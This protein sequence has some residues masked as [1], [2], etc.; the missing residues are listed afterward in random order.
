MIDA[1]KAIVGSKGIVQGEDVTAR[2]GW[3]G[4]ECASQ[5]LVRPKSTEE[6]SQVVALCYQNNQSM[7]VHGGRTGLVGGANADK[8][9]IIISLERMNQIETVNVENRTMV[10]EAGAILA[11]VQ[12]QAQQKNLEFTLDLG[13]R[14]SATVGGV[15]STNAGGNQVIRYGAARDQVL[16][17]EVV[18]PDGKVLNCM[19]QMLK[20]NAGYDLKHLF[21]GAEGSLGIITKA[22]IQLRPPMPHK[23]SALVAVN[24]FKHL[25]TLLNVCGAE[26]N[27]A[28]TAFEVM[29][30]SFI[31]VAAF[32]TRLP[33]F[34][35]S[36]NY[37]FYVLI[38][39]SG[40]NDESN[41]QQFIKTLESCIENELIVD[42]LVAQSEKERQYLW[43][44]RDNIDY[45]MSQLRPFCNF[46]IS[47]PIDTME[48]YI[49]TIKQQ[50]EQ[51][52]GD[53][54]WVIFG[55]LGDSNLHIIVS[56]DESVENCEQA[57]ETIVYNNLV[58]CN[59]SITA[60]HGIGIEK[61]SYLSLSR[62]E[63]YIDTM[64]QLKQL[65]DARNLMNSKIIF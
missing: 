11:Q 61:K 20:N 57:I 47:L 43:N 53:I 55:H 23:Q 17:I 32:D 3:H 10:V 59:G 19:N 48:S 31:L 22:V 18:L 45:L 58:P 46:D 39:Q 15:L 38:E 42:A 25:P 41:Q 62:D 28:L 40:T 50:L 13:A 49:D 5:L 54:K 35:L 6:L 63:T 33:K 9:D 44:I 56:I 30:Q 60:E 2:E 26:F 27:A 8:N 37:P 34:P 64:L 1:I 21:I 7:V 16:G 51:L 4:Y 29:W 12:Q 52:L 36:S 14:G 65:F 24:D